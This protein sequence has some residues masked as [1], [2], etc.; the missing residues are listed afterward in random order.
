MAGLLAEMA[1]AGQGT[2][3]ASWAGFLEE[4]AHSWSRDIKGILGRVPDRNGTQL[5]RWHWR[6]LGRIPGRN[7]TRL[8]RGHWRHLGQESV[9][10]W[11]SARNQE[12]SWLA[13]IRAMFYKRPTTSSSRWRWWRLCVLY[14]KELSWPVQ[15]LSRDNKMT[16]WDFSDSLPQTD[17]C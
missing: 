16:L 3:E 15:S 13:L 7:G 17:D 11:A 4:M 1:H 10:V 8:I 9:W 5:V 6:H 14:M 12:S 2:L